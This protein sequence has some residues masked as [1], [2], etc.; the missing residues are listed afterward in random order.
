MRE[1]A[2][3]LS[4]TLVFVGILALVSNV[5]R[6]ADLPDAI[7]CRLKLQSGI[8]LDARFYWS[9]QEVAFTQSVHYASLAVIGLNGSLQTDHLWHLLVDPNSQVIS[10]IILPSGTTTVNCHEGQL[11]SDL[12]ASGQV[13]SGLG[14]PH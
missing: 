10:S 9:F 14:K 6:A 1:L 7:I 12:L 2:G 5:T 3:R 13:L 4:K 11:L 8:E